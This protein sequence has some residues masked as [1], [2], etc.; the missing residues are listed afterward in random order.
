[1]QWEL[2]NFAIEKVNK[3]SDKDSSQWRRAR[4]FLDEGLYSCQ[5]WWAGAVPWWGVSFIE[6]GAYLLKRSVL[7]LPKLSKKDEQKPRTCTQR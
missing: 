6:E 5:Y 7:S 4:K 3:S 2:T 1:M